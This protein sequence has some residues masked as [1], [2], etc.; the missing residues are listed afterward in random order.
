[1]RR[2][3]RRAVTPSA[4][5]RKPGW[6]ERL[7]DIAFG[8]LIEAR[9]AE[10]LP[11]AALG[12]AEDLGWRRLTGNPERELISTSQ[13]RM[14][15]LCYWLWE[16]NP[17]AG[18]MIDLVVAFVLGEG[19]PYEA[20]DPDV[21]QILDDFWNNPVN[22]M[23]IY[24][25][26]HVRELGIFGELLFPATTAGQT[27][28]LY[29]GYIDPAQ[30]DAVVTDPE[31]VKMIIGVKL[32]DTVGKPGR[33][34]QT[35]LPAEADYVLSPTAKAMRK[36][37][38]DGECFYF[39]INNVTNSPR[40]R[41]DLIRV[42]DWLDAYEQFLYDYAE[43]WPLL[44]A[45]VWDLQVDDADPK[46]LDE[47]MKRFTKKSGSVYGHNQKVKLQA[48]TPD[49][50]AVDANEGARLLRNHILGSRS[51]PEHWYGGGGDVNRATASEMGEPIF[52]ML[53]MRQKIVKY[54]LEDMFTHAIRKARETGYARL[55]DEQAN[56]FSVVTP[57]LT[58]R[59]VSKFASAVQQIG[60]A[61]V[62]AETQGWIDKDTA[63][64]IFG[65]T[66]GFV[67]VE[68]DYEA[69]KKS[70]ADQADKKGYEDYG[71]D[72]KSVPGKAS[73]EQT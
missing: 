15:E 32:K 31:N 18:W 25:D 55:T 19:L 30:I 42:A 44:N 6:T 43:K 38:T 4:P 7:V 45:F 60:A 56:N 36:T 48:V 26:K 12:S 14:I 3:T 50:G 59:D 66:M 49:L 51:I 58:A 69:V 71:T 35:I 67:G 1:M 27:G 16:T 57:E 33:H 61:L 46:A 23:T 17:M 24:F 37:F 73:G 68:I 21:K 34:Y 8:S 40:G 10:R 41:S 52:K 47:E 2:I 22:R 28:R 65:V 62:G 9:V 5:S 72:L 64:K 13:E 63:G 20:E 70:L 53:S 29:L 39:S 11:A 54:I